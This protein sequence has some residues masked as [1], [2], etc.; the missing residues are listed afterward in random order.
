MVRHV[1][2]DERAFAARVSVR[3]SA[4]PSI[5]GSGSR[6][7]RRYA[8]WIAE[9]SREKL[10]DKTLPVKSQ[11]LSMHSYQVNSQWPLDQVID[12]YYTEF[13]SHVE[14]LDEMFK[15]YQKQKRTLGIADFDDLLC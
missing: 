9:E 5:Y 11:A 12:Q 10:G 13:E 6:R 14:I 2:W 3:A 15:Q 8:G 7:L 1:S 4:C